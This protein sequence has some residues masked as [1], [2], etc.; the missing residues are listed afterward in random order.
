MQ[1]INT[2]V[3][4]PWFFSVFFGTGVVLLFCALV[5]AL[6]S[7]EQYSI[8]NLFAAL[9]YN[10]GTIGVTIVRNVPLN[11]RMDKVDS[12]SSEAREFWRHY[13]KRWLFWNHVRTIAAAA[14][15]VWLIVATSV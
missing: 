5:P 9:L 11:N 1:A 6:R 3:Q 14:A 15:C 10:V 8:A 4:N 12:E 13:L 2:T 7:S